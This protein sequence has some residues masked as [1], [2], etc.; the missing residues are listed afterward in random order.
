MGTAKVS[1][2]IPCYN[3]AKYLRETLGSA[4]AQTHAPLEVIVIDDG[5]TD[6]SAA[7]AESFGP[8]VRVIRQSNQGESVARNRGIDEATGDWIAFLDADDWWE[9]TKL[10]QQVKVALESPRP[11]VC[12]YTGFYKFTLSSK[13]NPSLIVPW[14]EPEDRIMRLFDW[15]VMPSSAMVRRDVFGTLRFPVTIRHGED[16]IFFAQLRDL[17]E[18]YGIPAGLTGYRMSA[19]QQSKGPKHEFG[20]LDSA[21]SWFEANS[22]RY[23]SSERD[24]FM[25]VFTRKISNL[26]DRAYWLRDWNCVELIESYLAK[27]RGV[28]AFDQILRKWRYPR[29]VYRLRDVAW[30]LVSKGQRVSPVVPESVR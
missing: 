24:R 30:R 25:Q 9:T 5:S 13:R 29:W 7:I 19:S 11:Y 4:L 6:D 1:V 18:F 16:F 14:P 20:R 12:V 8:P 28:P 15:S 27:S 23:S 10:E 2:V 17:G 26:L 22:E 21:R 3:G